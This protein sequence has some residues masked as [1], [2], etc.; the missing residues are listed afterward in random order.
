MNETPTPV[1][2]TPAALATLYYYKPETG[3]PIAPAQ[4]IYIGR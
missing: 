4:K 3:Q 2:T 1:A